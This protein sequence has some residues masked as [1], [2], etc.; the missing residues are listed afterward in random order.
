VP[1][2]KSASKVEKLTP[3]LLTEH[4]DAIKGLGGALIVVR[5]NEG[6]WS[7][8]V[9]YAA[10]QKVAT[11]KSFPALKALPIL[12]ID[13]F[14]TYQEDEDRAILVNGK[15]IRLFGGSQFN[16]DIGQVVPADVTAD[17]RFVTTEMG[18]HA[19]PVGKAEVYIITKPMP[20]AK[21][22]A[23]PK[24]EVGAKFLPQ[25]YTGVYKLH[26]DGQRS[27]TLHL[28]VGDDNVVKG[29]FYSDKDGAKYD[30]DGKVSDPHHKIDFKIYYP[31]TVQE[32]HGWMFTAN[33]KAFAGWTRLENRETGF[34][35][36][37]QET[38]A[39]PKK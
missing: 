21:P 5:T 38:K 9:V 36:V 19:V 20:E 39:E 3:E 27:G 8:L 7:K 25:Y 23:S 37:R 31:R 4:S 34:Y 11:E 15:N 35:A 6:R 14:V 12:L 1:Q 30:V 29:H 22:D 18:E 2:S 24:I 16:L 32:L 28:K 26:D 10:K 17:L 33:G 13:R